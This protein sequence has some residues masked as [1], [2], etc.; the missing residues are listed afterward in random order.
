[1][2]VGQYEFFSSMIKRNSKLASSSLQKLLNSLRINDRMIVFDIFGYL[3]V[4]AV[5]DIRRLYWWNFS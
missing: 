2:G 5:D 4:L 3:T 1:M